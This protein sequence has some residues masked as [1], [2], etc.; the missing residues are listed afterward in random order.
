MKDF[1]SHQTNARKNG[2]INERRKKKSTIINEETNVNG[3]L[4]K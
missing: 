4:K 3:L 1:N 2:R